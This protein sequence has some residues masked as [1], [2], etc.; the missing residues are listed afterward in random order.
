MRF[1]LNLSIAV[2]ERTP[3]VLR[4][5]LGGL[6]DD[7]TRATEGP[8]TWSPCDVVGHLIH[9]DRTDWIPRLDIILGDGPDRTFHPF[10][11]FAQFRESEGK[12]LDRL[13]DE[14]AEVRA[15]S[16]SAL[17]ARQLTDADL[18]RTGI[19]PTFGT[20]NARQLL[21]T[22]TVHDLDHLVQISRVM[23]RQLH[24]EVGPWIAFL[25][26]VREPVGR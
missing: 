3:V 15:A 17:R 24:D 1:D 10:D 7:W 12:S 25:R 8:D 6:S 13:L 22:W 19:H 5:L 11:R 2:L 14:F 26:V 9:G 16:L 21:S 4:S 18:D 23:A 20:V